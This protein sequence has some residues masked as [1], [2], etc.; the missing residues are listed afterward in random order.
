MSVFTDSDVTRLQQL[1]TTYDGAAEQDPARASD[2]R[3]IARHLRELA[4]KI[5][6]AIRTG[7]VPHRQPLTKRQAEVYRWVFQY[8]AIAGYAPT[9]EE[10]ADR[11]GFA[12]LA[13]VVEHLQ[14]LER[15]GYLR[16]EYNNARAITCLIHAD[17]IALVPSAPTVE[18]K[19]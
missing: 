11:F 4:G 17:E 2:Y 1:A 18:V 6:K 15:K 5:V 16:R 9:C 14:N 7:A 3:G 12:S 13:T 19:A 10:I 8:I